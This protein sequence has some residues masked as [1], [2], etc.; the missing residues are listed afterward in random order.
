M[1]WVRSTPVL[2]AAQGLRMRKVMIRQRNH[3][4]SATCIHAMGQSQ[5]AKGI[6]QRVDTVQREVKVLMQNGLGLFD[7]PP[8]CPIFLHGERIKLRMIQPRDHV[9]IRFIAGEELPMATSVEVQPDS[10]FSCFRL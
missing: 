1:L 2:T 4:E 6:V 5:F 10:S 9:N 3:L 8:D 7:I